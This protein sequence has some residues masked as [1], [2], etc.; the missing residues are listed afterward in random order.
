MLRQENG[1]HF[2]FIRSE[3]ELKKRLILI[4]FAVLLLGV[5][6]LVYWGQRNE[7]IAELYY[8]GTI[9]ATQANLAFQVS[10]R[11]SEVFFD[12]GQAVEKNQLLAV[13]AQEEFNARRNKAQ[14]DLV[15]SREN[16]KQL[17]TLLALNR[18]VLP[19]EV[20]RV[21]ASVQALQSQLAELEAGYRVQE[22]D[23]ARY[24][25]ERAQFALEEAHKDK[26]RFDRLFERKIIAENDKDATDLKY[27]NALKG[28]ESAKK[29]FELFKE[30]YRKESI[31]TARSKLAEGRAALKQAKDNLK[32]IEAA[33]QEVEAG[34]AQVLSAKAALE[35]AKIQLNYSELRTPFNG[36]LV[37][38]NVEPGEVVSPG[39]EV[40]SLA[41]LSKVDLKVFVAETEIG[42]VR[43]GQKVDVKIDTFPSRTYTGHVSFISPEGEFTPKIIQT[44]KERVK[45]VYL[46]KITI[47]NPNL[48]LKTGMP[49]DAWFR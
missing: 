11:V 34:K 25:Y 21:E 42:K 14:S 19:A 15:Q 26:I 18:K 10:G 16:L 36:I 5:G 1:I 47:P 6:I 33:E 29:N 27:E 7:R 40:I 12:E 38:R 20:E 23:Q 32:K 30:G 37:S 45:L 24:A 8:S 31:A 39:Q 46:V 48:E 3:V 9:E 43:P 35:L 2:F 4:V 41:D 44:H 22:V 17:E 28:Y 13:L 49:A